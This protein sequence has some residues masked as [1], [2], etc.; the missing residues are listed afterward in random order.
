MIETDKIAIF[1]LS[2]ITSRTVPDQELVKLSMILVRV[3]LPSA[4][5]KVEEVLKQYKHIKLI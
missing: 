2:K 5:N 1:G 3:S 4:C